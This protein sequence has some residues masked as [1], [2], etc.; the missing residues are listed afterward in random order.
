MT[1][2]RTC[3]TDSC[4]LLEVE[5][6][7]GVTQSSVPGGTA[8]LMWRDAHSTCV[9]GNLGPGCALG[10]CSG[11]GV[12]FIMVRVRGHKNGGRRRKHKAQT[13]ELE[14]QELQLV[15][16][17]SGQTL[18]LM[19]ISLGTIGPMISLSSNDRCWTLP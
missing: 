15:L 13:P 5:S 18:S 11:C 14:S 17:L 16:G 2:S 9:P 4:V 10:T 7:S 3:D 12:R 6:Y 19:P 8:V 1:D